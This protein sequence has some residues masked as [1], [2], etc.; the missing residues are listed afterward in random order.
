MEFNPKTVTYSRRNNAI[1][2]WLRATLIRFSSKT[3]SPTSPKTYKYPLWFS[4]Q[5]SQAD[6]ENPR[7]HQAIMRGLLQKVFGTPVSVA[8]ELKAALYLRH[9]EHTQRQQAALGLL[10]KKKEVSLF[11][12]L[13]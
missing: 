10:F 7:R 8:P 11:I 3:G 1:N 4:V 13:N 9:P 2:A 12:H 6:L 5:Y